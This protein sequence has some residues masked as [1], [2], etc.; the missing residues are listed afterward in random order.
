VFSL[1][2]DF[3]QDGESALICL[4]GIVSDSLRY[5]SGP[6]SIS[7][8]CLV[9][10]FPFFLWNKRK[11]FIFKFLVLKHKTIKKNLSFICLVK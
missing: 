4:L 7:W 2:R 1:N 3:R 11:E 8:T 5:V 9:I 6:K 10:I